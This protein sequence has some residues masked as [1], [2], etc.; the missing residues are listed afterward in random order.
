MA[1]IPRPRVR[2]LLASKAITIDHS[3]VVPGAHGDPIHTGTLT[4]LLA[5]R[6]GIIV[7]A[8]PSPLKPIGLLV[9][10]DR[11]ELAITSLAIL[12]NKD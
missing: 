7:L 4:K 10:M 2:D 11:F 6:A 9:K 1:R 5:G 8:V 12:L 3:V